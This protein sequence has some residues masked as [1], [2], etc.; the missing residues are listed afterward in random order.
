MS[1]EHW[2]RHAVCFESMPA[3]CCLCCCC[4]CCCCWMMIRWWCSLLW[5]R[6]WGWGWGWGCRWI[7]A[8]ACLTCIPLFAGYAQNL[9][10]RFTQSCCLPRSPSQVATLGT[11]GSVF[12][13]NPIF[14]LERFVMLWQLCGRQLCDSYVAVYAVTAMWQQMPGVGTAWVGLLHTAQ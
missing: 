13:W 4:R 8:M 5:Q 9:Q 14:L 6:L 11:G 12:L 3:C 7:E 2:K 1:G 10:P